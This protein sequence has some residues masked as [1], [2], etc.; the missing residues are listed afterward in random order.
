MWLR[1][2]VLANVLFLLSGKVTAQ[3]IFD[4][5]PPAILETPLN[6]TLELTSKSF[7]F[8][9]CTLG[10]EWLKGYLSN[11]DLPLYVS[12]KL[13]QDGLS[14][15][16]NETGG[17]GELSN[18]EIMRWLFAN[19]TDNQANE[20]MATIHDFSTGEQCLDIA[21]PIL[22][23]QGHPDLAGRG[24]LST[25]IVQASLTTIYATVIIAMRLGWL[26]DKQVR[27]S[28]RMRGLSAI[29]H[30]T[31]TFLDASLVFSISMLVAAIVTYSRALYKDATQP[32]TYASLTTSYLS[33]YAVLPTLLLQICAS[34]SLRRTKW[35][36]TVWGLIAA[37]TSAVV[38][39]FYWLPYLPEQ[40]DEDGV[41]YRDS[42][43]RYRLINDPESQIKWEAL[44]VDTAMTRNF[45][46][47]IMA[48]VIGLF[49]AS[50]VSV[51][52]ICTPE[53]WRP[54]TIAKVWKHLWI[55]TALICFVGMWVSLGYF[56][57]FRELFNGKG[58]A[59]NKD[60]E[61]SFGQVLSM[62]NWA[63][64]VIEFVYIWTH[65]ARRALTG[66][67]MG[68]YEAVVVEE[69]GDGEEKEERR[70][71]EQGKPYQPVTPSDSDDSGGPRDAPEQRSD[72][73]HHHRLHC[74]PRGDPNLFKKL[75]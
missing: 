27:K 23:W 19:I 32:S 53:S 10:G 71:E 31:R 25:Y 28:V 50:G 33:I 46:T 55:T 18:M 48:L 11:D 15:V 30:S 41:A 12:T 17:A 63:P 20:V 36:A 7:Q 13:I 60:R 70:D 75:R 22:G 34:N 56:L 62:A 49:V 64:V 2:T 16:W 69:P 39:L 1:A 42:T 74:T 73:E 59:S 3:R 57:F 43:G 5:Q 52:L 6:G 8:T 26:P 21:C 47:I 35:R 51:I 66:Q 45:R 40:A 38:A 4:P 54:K 9:N 29:K 44:C 68:P 58:G 65:G 24:M 37:L 72:A 67:M 61:W 14:W